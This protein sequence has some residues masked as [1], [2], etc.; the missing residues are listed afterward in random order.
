MLGVLHKVT[1]GIAPAQLAA[2]FPLR[3]SV[4]EH[5]CAHRMRYWRPLHSCQLLSH[6]ER[7]STETM[8]RSL[9][10]LVHCYNL[11]P[12]GVVDSRSVK[13]FQGKL[14]VALGVYAA[15]SPDGDWPRLYSRGWRSLERR[16]L[17][18]LFR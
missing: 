9:F 8:R 4:V 3:G 2:L 5:R 15:Q 1:L 6:A 16:A 10:G 14:Q 18:R 11:L 13:V 17:D 12:Q 7:D